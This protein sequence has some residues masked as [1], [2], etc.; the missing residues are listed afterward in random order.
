MHPLS[1]DKVNNVLALLAQGISTRDIAHRTGVSKSK[2]AEIAKESGQNKENHHPGHPSK[3][4]PRNV[5]TAV[6]LVVS[7]RADTAAATTRQLNSAN[8]TSI[9][10]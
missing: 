1:S 9:C 4:S 6:S 8:I 3:L 7:G 5:K 10:S 2:V